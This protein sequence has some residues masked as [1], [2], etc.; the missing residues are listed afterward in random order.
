MKPIKNSDLNYF[1][2]AMM[3]IALYG[4]VEIEDDLGAVFKKARTTSEPTMA[5]YHL[6]QIYNELQPTDQ[7]ILRERK[8][9][10]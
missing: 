1:E 9:I 3:R 8:V 6:W 5:L 7:D 10:K 4:Y 2:K